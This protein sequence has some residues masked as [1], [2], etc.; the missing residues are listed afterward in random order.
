M[1][2][3]LINTTNAQNPSNGSMEFPEMLSHYENA[4]GNTPLTNEERNSM[5]SLMASSSS[6]SGTNNA[7]ASPMTRPVPLNEI[8]YT[9]AE[10]EALMKLQDEQTNRIADVRTV[11]EPHSPS[12]TIPG[13]ENASYF[14]GAD[15]SDPNLSNLDLDQYLDSG[16]FYN[17]SS[18][19]AQADYDY[20]Q[21][22]SGMGDSHFDVGM[23]GTDETRIIE[24]MDNSEAATPEEGNPELNNNTNSMRSPT[25]KRR[26]N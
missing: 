15:S 23:D 17:G 11:L 6:V 19:M 26:K 18:P 5:L 21:F 14:N 22:D 2:M 13:L 20:G 4:N 10:I 12:G 16:A 7:L 9:Q 3:S 1:M 25:K 8:Q 24:T